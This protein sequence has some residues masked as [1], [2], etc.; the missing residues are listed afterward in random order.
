MKTSVP[1]TPDFSQGRKVRAESEL[2]PIA[3]YRYRVNLDARA[4]EDPKT[5]DD[6]AHSLDSVHRSGLHQQGM[7][8][9]WSNRIA[10][11]ASLCL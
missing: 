5:N 8:A 4:T 7:L 6:E 1:E 11:Q 10:D 2:A 9:M 3:A